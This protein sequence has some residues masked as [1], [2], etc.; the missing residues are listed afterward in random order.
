VRKEWKKREDD[1]RAERQKNG[2]KKSGKAGKGKG[3]IT[4]HEIMKESI[5]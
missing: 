3:G 4:K 2:G 1:I 5:R